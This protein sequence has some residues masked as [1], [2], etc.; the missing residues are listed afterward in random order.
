MAVQTVP[1]SVNIDDVMTP[2]FVGVSKSAVATA[3]VTA[4]MPVPG[5]DVVATDRPAPL[6]ANWN[7]IAYGNEIFLAV[8]SSTGVTGESPW[9]A[10]SVDG[11]TWALRIM[12]VS[13]SWGSIAFGNGKFVIVADGSTTA[14]VTTDGF[15]WK[16]N[17]L[18]RNGRY[19]SIQYGGGQFITIGWNSS[20][21][22]VSTDGSL[23]EYRALPAS[24]NW[25]SLAYDACLGRWV[26]IASNSDKGAYSDDGS[27]WIEMNMVKNSSW[28]SVA[29]N[30]RGMFVAVANSLDTSTISYS[31]DG[32]NWNYANGDTTDSFALKAV[33]YAENYHPDYGAKWWALSNNTRNYSSD[34]G[35]TWVRSSSVTTAKEYTCVIPAYI[36]W[37]TNDTLI[38]NNGAVVTVNTNQTKFWSGIT[39]NDG[40]LNIVNSSSTNAIRF[41]TGR[42]SGAAAQTI[43]PASALG[44][45]NV[46]GGWI[47]L[48]VGTGLPN[49]RITVPYTDY[50]PAVWVETEKDS[51]IFEIWLNVTG[52]YGGTVPKFVEGLESVS[53]GQRGKFFVQE[54][55]VNQDTIILINNVSTNI[56]SRR[57]I[58]SDTTGLFPGAQIS[59]KSSP[60]IPAASVIE[61]IIDGSTIDINLPC[62][63]QSTVADVSIY[64][65]YVAQLSNVIRFGDGINGNVIPAGARVRIPNIM[66]TSDTPA[67]LQ[68]S[69]LRL[70]LN[71]VMTNEGNINLENCLIDE[72]YIDFTQAQSVRIKNVGMWNQ[73]VLSRCYD[74]NIDGLGIALPPIRRWYNPAGVGWITRGLRDDFTS[75]FIS[76]T[77]YATYLNNMS[78]NNLVAVSNELSMTAGTASSPLG[79][80]SIGYSSGI[81][82]TNLRLYKLQNYIAGHY[83]IAL[84][85]YVTNS[86][87]SNIE[88]YGMM[89]VAISSSFNNTF[90]NITYSHD[91]R[92]MTMGYSPGQRIGYD[93][94]TDEKLVDNTPYYFKVR[95]FFTRD[96]SVYVDSSEFSSTP[97]LGD[98]YFPDY[99]TCYANAS[100]SVLLAWPQRDPTHQNPAYEIYRGTSPGFTRD[101]SSLIFRTDSSTTLTWTDTH[102]KPVITASTSRS[103]TFDG[104][105]CGRI[106]LSG[107]APGTWIDGS[108]FINDKLIVTGTNLN[109]GVYTV[110]AFDSS[111]ILRVNE[112]MATEPIYTSSATITVV[113]DKVKQPLTASPER[114]LTFNSDKTITL[115]GTDTFSSFINLGFIVGDVVDITGC[116]DPTNNGKKTIT[117][118][119]HKVMTVREALVTESTYSSSATIAGQS[120][121]DG[122]TYYYVLRKYDPPMFGS[123]THD[124]AEQEVYVHDPNKISTN[125]LLYNNAFDNAVWIK[126]NATVIANQ[127]ISPVALPNVADTTYDADLLVATADNGNISQRFK[128]AIDAS[129]NFSVFVA[130]QPYNSS[131]NTISGVIMLKGINN[132]ST[133]FVVDSSFRR[134]DVTLK[135]DASSLVA[136]IFIN[137]NGGR[138]LLA[139]A[140]ANLGETPDPPIPTTTAPVTNVNSTRYPILM[141]SWCRSYGNE[142]HNSGIEIQYHGTVP[143]GTV[144][145]EVYCSSTRGFT[146][147]LQNRVANITNT[148][149]NPSIVNLYISSYNTIS[150]I[151]QVNKAFAAT[152]AAYAI[153]GLYGSNSTIKNA[154]MYL[155]YCNIANLIY[156][157]TGS[158]NIFIHNWDV[159]GYNNYTSKPIVFRTTVANLAAGV[160]I[161]NLRMDNSDNP[162][163]STIS[164]TIIKGM[165]GAN[166]SPANNAITYQ[167]GSTVDGAATEYL[168]VYDSIFNEFY[169]S[170]STGALHINF[171]ASLK[172]PPPYV[173]L[174][175]SKFS[176]TGK[177]FLQNPSDGIIYTWP[178]RI[179]GVKGFRAVPRTYL[180]DGSI[181]GILDMYKVNGLD[182]GTTDDLLEGLDI[183]YD[184]DKGS[185]YT[186][187]RS[188][189]SSNM[190]AETIS[191][192]EG[193]LL[194]IK[195]EA[196]KFMKYS[197]KSS[198]FIIGETITGRTSRATAKVDNLFEVSTGSLIGTIW[199]SD[200]SGTFIA[201]EIIES[202]TGVTRATNVATN[203]FPFGP[204]F[205]SY[206]DGLQLYTY[207]DTSVL[208]PSETITL[209]MIVKDESNNP[210]VGANAF[211]D[212]AEA[213]APFIMNTSTNASGIASVSYSGGPTTGSI[214]RVR[215]YGYKPY[216]QRIDIEDEDI[217][218]P[219]TLIADPQQ[220]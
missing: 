213:T 186:G 210:I 32:I 34:N 64:N 204:S 45:I 23:W 94:I 185:G 57:I 87:F 143:A 219:I 179:Y 167:L 192:S 107:T 136:T 118:L 98:K 140:M 93:P 128:T 67:N 4:P 207:I 48:S 73:S 116:M 217:T 198:A 189:T 52:S 157:A 151:T 24:R 88:T 168:A 63:A 216:S 82:A 191:P 150:N 131:S 203:I 54:P 133:N 215:K 146:P 113:H 80:L 33:C 104:S 161:Q 155:N 112:P 135:A 86:N 29:S 102:T 66:L 158:Y 132:A 115:G 144:W 110:K 208:Y 120:I 121:N 71:F 17:S 9:A 70:N 196:V 159:G 75:V 166:A 7:G 134:V 176:N 145:T 95:N 13:A 211:I 91:M 111:L 103:L 197:T 77:I 212:D 36:P 193:F 187:F 43:A 39:I 202:S 201:G 169:W 178:H 16:I 53:N 65:P 6:D 92:N 8:S 173:L 164:N 15:N 60:A 28:N 55:A 5:A 30:N 84:R 220:I 163:S 40:V 183:K 175:S 25:S 206:I 205:T 76:T 3:F 99:L 41:T 171:N 59:S 35:I 19:L 129:Y 50:V 114:T 58:L 154:K 38:I 109:N 101:L 124:S 108:I 89:P 49:Q 195:L 79:L 149:Y 188:C 46:Q 160:T 209:Q 147:S 142:D 90:T 81:K 141:R 148:T 194:K 47:D 122:S 83:G 61:R 170:A 105:T 127:A 31:T 139:A 51:S 12:P 138:L 10:S 152:Y 137:K 119:T 27:V 156:S 42:T 174:G 26:A 85:G 62:N 165:S 78:I 184:I 72:A 117:A 153:A 20:T 162:V 106:I 190:L 1:K 21:A 68:T 125:R 69:S 97:F 200:V 182:L 2:W 180:Q 18:E 37:R 177:L 218:L 96:R 126:T 123:A 100:K 44:S 199:V 214:W 22:Q 172:N 181:S 56:Q 130:N 74:V 11:S 14:L